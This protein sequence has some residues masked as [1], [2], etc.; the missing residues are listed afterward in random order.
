MSDSKWQATTPRRRGLTLHAWRWDL[1][2]SSEGRGQPRQTVG[3]CGGAALVETKRL[4][5][6]FF[7][8]EHLEQKNAPRYEHMYYWASGLFIGAPKA[9]KHFCIRGL[10]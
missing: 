1:G 6:S 10:Y 3:K 2:T 4:A 5:L 9:L 8:V 7:R